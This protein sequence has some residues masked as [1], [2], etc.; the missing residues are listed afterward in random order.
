MLKNS[1][2]NKHFQPLIHTRTIA[3]HGENKWAIL[4]VTNVFV[5]INSFQ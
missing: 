1:S 5:K 4:N 3:C 2:K